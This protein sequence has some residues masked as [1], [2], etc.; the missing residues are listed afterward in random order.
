MAA[1]KG[2]NW[3]KKHDKEDKETKRQMEG[4]GTNYRKVTFIIKNTRT[5]RNVSEKRKP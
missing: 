2:G 4:K 5:R 1:N 3:H